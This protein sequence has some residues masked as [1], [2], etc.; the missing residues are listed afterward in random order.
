MAGICFYRP[1]RLQP[2]DFAIFLAVMVVPFPPRISWQNRS[3]PFPPRRSIGY[4]R[5]WGSHHA[6]LGP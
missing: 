2:G 6:G 4:L 1:G 3:Q 5:G